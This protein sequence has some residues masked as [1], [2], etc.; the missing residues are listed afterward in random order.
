M[1]ILLII[2]I[3]PIVLQVSIADLVK[4]QKGDLLFIQ[5][6]DNLPIQVPATVAM[7]TNHPSEVLL[8]QSSPITIIPGSQT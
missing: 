6:P 3:K 2:L 7:N 8:P 1:M 5:L 4:T